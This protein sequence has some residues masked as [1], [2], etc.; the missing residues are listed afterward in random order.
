MTEYDENEEKLLKELLLGK[1]EQPKINIDEI[2]R[3]RKIKQT[4]FKQY[5]EDK[6]LM[7]LLTNILVEFY[8]NNDKP[9]D[10]ILFIKEFLSKSG[11]IDIKKLTKENE[12]MKIKLEN[13]KIK[14]NELKEQ[15]K[16]YQS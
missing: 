11:G 8:E 10:P 2:N 9:K 13:L 5:L 4:E 15:L 3:E 6:Q 12:D 16:D 14:L 1:E 7:N